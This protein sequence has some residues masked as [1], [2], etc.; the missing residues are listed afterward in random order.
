M[1]V[2]NRAF[3]GR[4]WHLLEPDWAHNVVIAGRGFFNAAQTPG[5]EDYA[6]AARSSDGKL[7][8]AYMPTARSITVQM[9]RL[10]A[11]AAAQWFDPTSGDVV[12]IEE[13]RL[14]NRGNRDF[15]PPGKNR[16][17]DSDWV[18]I[19]ETDPPGPER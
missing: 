1:G 11:P 15:T 10:A 4:P 13:G 14:P 3:L 9:N 17:G 12:R 8:M 18:L 16:D 2:L 19:L 5:G 7:V 6:T